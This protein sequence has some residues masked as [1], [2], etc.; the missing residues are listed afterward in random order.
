MEQ[1]FNVLEL[2]NYNYIPYLYFKATTSR[3]TPTNT[4]A[5]FIAM[6]IDDKYK[7]DPA[8]EADAAASSSTQ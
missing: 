6:D 4:K 7:I 2:D 5:K 3:T 1:I 8:D